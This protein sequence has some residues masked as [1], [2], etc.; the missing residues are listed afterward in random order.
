[1]STLKRCPCG[2]IPKDLD[3]NI[4]E[5]TR[6]GFATPTCCND[7]SIEFRHDY[8]KEGMLQS[9]AELAWNN[10]PR[11]FEGTNHRVKI[12]EEHAKNHLEGLKPWELRKNDRNYQVGDVI[13]FV[14]I[15]TDKNPTGQEYTRVITYVY[16]GGEYGLAHDYCIL[17]LAELNPCLK[18]ST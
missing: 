10:A 16:L 3:I 17:T 13:E 9:M 4:S 2:Q 15:D 1:M 5:G 6:F 11:H 14:V 7:W 12:L 8:A 18:T